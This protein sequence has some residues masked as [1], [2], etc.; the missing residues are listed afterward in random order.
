MAYFWNM[1]NSKE[2]PS[3]RKFTSKSTNQQEVEASQEPKRGKSR[4]TPQAE[5]KIKLKY[6]F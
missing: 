1:T 2:N 6:N 4:A 3:K 5:D